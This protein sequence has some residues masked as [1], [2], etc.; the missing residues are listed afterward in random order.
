MLDQI[1]NI[2]SQRFALTQTVGLFLSVFSDKWLVI[3]S[4]WV[5]I[6]DKPLSITIEIL[7]NHLVKD[8]AKL[9]IADVVTGYQTINDID[10]LS[11]LDIRT[12]WVCMMSKDQIIGAILPDTQWVDS[13]SYAYALLREKNKFNGDV[14]VLTFTTQR[15]L[16]KS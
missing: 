7:Y 15:L 16:I 10:I 13:P 9:I 2:V 11:K 3:G 4:Q 12:N 8:P 5:V 14:Q 1:K 6:A